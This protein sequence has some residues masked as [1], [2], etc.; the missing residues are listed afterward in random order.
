V[1]VRGKNSSLRPLRLCEKKF[2]A[3]TVAALF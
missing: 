1:L 3:V 2:L